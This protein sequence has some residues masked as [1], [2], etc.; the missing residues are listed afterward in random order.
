MKKT[1]YVMRHGQTLFNEQR[2]VQGWCDSPLT[3]LGI[4]Q[5]KIARDYFLENGITFDAAYCSPLGRACETIEI[6][7]DGKLDY[8]RVTDLKERNFGII[9]GS[10]EFSLEKNGFP[11]GDWMLEYGAEKESDFRNRVSAAI[12][13][14]AENEGNSILILAHGGTCA[15]FAIENDEHAFYHFNE[16]AGNCAIYVYD[17]KSGI[18]SLQNVVEHGI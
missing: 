1:I 9:E 5:A 8:I 3:E 15:E 11:F 7:L 4:Y 18:F 17:Y 12:N 2:R 14:I 6:I 13:N 16:V 10:R